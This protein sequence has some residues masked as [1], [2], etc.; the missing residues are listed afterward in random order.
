M[1][2]S[3][4]VFLV[5]AADSITRQVL[6]DHPDGLDVTVVAEGRLDPHAVEDLD[7]AMR[8]QIADVGRLAEPRRIVYADLGLEP[9]T[10]VGESPP[11]GPAGRLVATAGAIDALDVIDGDRD[12]EGVWISER[13][14]DR[15]DLPAGTLVSINDEPRAGRRRL[16]QP[17]GG[18]PSSVLGRPA[19]ALRA[20]FLAS[21]RRDPLSR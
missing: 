16:R 18:R 1:A 3:A 10:P 11:V 21:V 7:E 2:A 12:A 19:R 6:A 20:P 4:D 17:L 14:S 13:T 15:F 8:T 5:S 9:P